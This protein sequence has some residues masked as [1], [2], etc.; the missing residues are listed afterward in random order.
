MVIA[1]LTNQDRG[2][3]AASMILVLRGGVLMSAGDLPE[4]LRHLST[5]NLSGEIGRTQIVLLDAF[6]VKTRS[7]HAPPMPVVIILIY[8]IS[9]S[10]SQTSSKYVV[11]PWQANISLLPQR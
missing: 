11:N 8:A 4:I 6:A 5:D 7:R 1:P 2:G 10:G 3:F 9:N